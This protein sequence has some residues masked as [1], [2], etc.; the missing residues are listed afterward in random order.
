[1]LPSAFSE[2]Q[3]FGFQSGFMGWGQQSRVGSI[4]RAH[5]GTLLLN[6]IDH[7]DFD[8]QSRLL[9]FLESHSFRMLGQETFSTANCQILSTS[10]RNLTNLSSLGLFS[11]SLFNRI[12]QVSLE[13]PPLSERSQLLPQLIDLLLFHIADLTSHAKPR[14]SQDS[15]QLLA[16]YSFP[17]D[18]TELIHIC[19][20]ACS[21]SQFNIILPDHLPPFSPTIRHLSPLS[22]LKSPLS[23]NQDI[24]NLQEIEI[25]NYVHHHGCITNA[26]CRKLLKIDRFRASY[27]LKKLHASNILVRIGLGRNSHYSKP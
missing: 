18:V 8:F 6:Q 13:I 24:P 21:E 9:N 15:L 3:F 20:V 7:L 19:L 5:N 10:A 14:I 4:P 16:Q 26:L 23:P 25:L 1:M 12:T 27:L 2:A 11:L 17:G 22:P